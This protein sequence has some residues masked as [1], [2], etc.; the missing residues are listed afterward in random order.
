VKETKQ[1]HFFLSRDDLHNYI[2][3][4]FGKAVTGTVLPH[5]I[6]MVLRAKQNNRQNYSS[7]CF[8]LCIFE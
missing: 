2:L 4:S 8:N 3:I 7:V 6:C 5:F 1:K